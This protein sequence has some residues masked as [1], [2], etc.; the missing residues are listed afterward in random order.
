MIA[1][2]SES[3]MGATKEGVTVWGL[4]ISQKGKLSDSAASANE[5]LFGIRLLKKD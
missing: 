3:N 5:H 1:S 4:L 2:G